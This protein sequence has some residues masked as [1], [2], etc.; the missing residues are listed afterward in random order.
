MHHGEK[1]AAVIVARMGSSRLK[2]KMI[3][4]FGETDII[5]SVFDRIRKCALV[6]QFVFATTT[7]PL[8][9][10][11]AEIAAE[12]GLSVVRGSENDVVSRMA[13]A[14]NAL[15][16]R[17]DVIV[18]VCS[19]NPLLMPPVID[20]A[21]R[22]LCDNDADIVTPFEFGTYPFGY[23][24]VVMTMRTMDR[25][26]TE[27][28]EKTHREHVENFCFDNTGSFRIRYQLAPEPLCLSELFLTLDYDLDYRRLCLAQKGIA[29]KPVA[30]QHQALADWVRACRIALDIRET[31]VREAMTEVLK[32]MG[33]TVLDDTLDADLLISDQEPVRTPDT[34]RGALYPDPDVA[35]RLLYTHRDLDEP[36]ACFQYDGPNAPFGPFLLEAALVRMAVRAAAGF[37][38]SVGQ[39]VRFLPAAEKVSSTSRPGFKTNNAALFPPVLTVP[40]TLPAPCRERL[41]RELSLDV[42]RECKV[43]RFPNT[44]TPEEAVF[45]ILELAE[46]GDIKTPASDKVLGNITSRTIQEAWQ[47]PAMQRLRGAI[48]NGDL[49]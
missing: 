40:E 34:P 42:A 7:N 33:F 31:D 30:I 2:D 12:E 49:I 44:L 41:D 11:L 45:T 22:E 48:L 32:R 6:D 35:G 28:T 27:A 5:R 38:P 25:I 15:P 20:D 43:T 17:P 39:R 8:D 36:Y 24:A 26:T 9:D 19:D 46:N 18:R 14:I 16:E 37:P 3:L 1:V 13:D 29:A 10:I 4:P 23:G 21:V 47:S